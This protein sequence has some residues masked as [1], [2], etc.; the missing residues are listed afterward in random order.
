MISS[1]ERLMPPSIGLKMS[2]VICG[3]SAVVFP[4]AFASSIGSFF[5]Q[6][7][8]V[9]DRKVPRQTPSRLRQRRPRLAW[10][11]A[12]TEASLISL[13]RTV[14]QENSNR[15]PLTIS[16]KRPGTTPRTCLDEKLLARN[17]EPRMSND[18]RSPNDLMTKRQ[19]ESFLT[20]GFR[21]SFV[22]RHSTFVIWAA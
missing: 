22:L 9:R 15:L 1:G 2:A 10:R 6:P 11:N 19:A 20:F 16:N 12:F 7:E 5:S 13:L 14:R 8:N 21:H 18:E 4:A 17:D 3:K